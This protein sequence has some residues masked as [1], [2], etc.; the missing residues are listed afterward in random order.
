VKL[1]S[2]EMPI[3][4]IAAELTAQHPGVLEFSLTKNPFVEVDSARIDTI[5]MAYVR[6][7]KKPVGEEARRLEQ[8]LRARTKTT[9]LKLVIE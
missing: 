3:K 8:W 1:R 2:Q 6:F 9:R 4:D 7:A 5:T